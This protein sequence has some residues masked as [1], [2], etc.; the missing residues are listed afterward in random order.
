MDSAVCRLRIDLVGEDLF[1]VGLGDSQVEAGEQ[2]GQGFVEGCSGPSTLRCT[3][4]TLL[5]SFS[6]SA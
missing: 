3:S 6:A 4:K 5:R 1:V 2:L